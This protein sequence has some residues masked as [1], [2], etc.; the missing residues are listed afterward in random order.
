LAEARDTARVEAFSDGLFA[1]AMTL[2]V[3]EIRVPDLPPGATNRELGQALVALWPSLIAFVASFGTILTMWTHHH[4]LCTFVR[5]VDRRL[6]FSN[7]FLL[8]LVTFVPFPTAVAARNVGCS[9]AR[10]A[11]MFYCATFLMMALAFQVFFAAVV[12]DGD[13]P[14]PDAERRVLDAIR[15]GYAL[16]PF[17]Y[18]GAALLA[19]FSPL[20]GFLVCAIMWIFWSLTDYRRGRE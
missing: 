1:I 2:L 17:S 6:F 13:V 19:F 16:G 5:R 8:L 3:L 7:G 12:R 9:A 20:L 11:T 15:R 4:H 14:R 18:A 10:T